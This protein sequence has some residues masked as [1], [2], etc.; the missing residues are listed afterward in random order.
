MNINWKEIRATIQDLLL[1]AGLFIAVISGLILIT[2]AI[3]MGIEPHWTGMIVLA[4]IIVPLALGPYMLF[5]HSPW[6]IR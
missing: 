3:V 1:I 2:K 4:A 6:G 5:K